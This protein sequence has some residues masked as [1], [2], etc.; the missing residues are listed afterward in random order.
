MSQT[1]QAVVVMAG[2]LLMCTPF[3]AE[4]DK[5]AS[6]VGPLLLKQFDGADVRI[7][8]LT[9]GSFDGVGFSTCTTRA[10]FDSEYSE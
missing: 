3:Y 2:E 4:N 1:Y 10:V 9:I 5:E 6:E 7:F 8:D